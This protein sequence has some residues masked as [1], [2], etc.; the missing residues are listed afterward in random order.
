MRL[1]KPSK[2]IPFVSSQQPFFGCAEDV[3]RD[4]GN[5]W[6]GSDWDTAVFFRAALPRQTMADVMIDLAL[7]KEETRKNYTWG[8]AATKA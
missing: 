1:R 6:V 4:H 7:S 2:N 8:K 5:A 3:S